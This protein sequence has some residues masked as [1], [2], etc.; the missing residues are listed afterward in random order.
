MYVCV[1]VYI[2]IY[3]LYIY[4]YGL[5]PHGLPPPAPKVPRRG[6][7]AA[8]DT[9][10]PICQSGTASARGGECSPGRAAKKCRGVWQFG[11]QDPNFGPI[12]TSMASIWSPS[13][14]LWAQLQPNIPIEPHFHLRTTWAHDSATWFQVGVAGRPPSWA[15]LGPNPGQFCRFNAAR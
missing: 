9:N 14:S 7:L 8:S 11:Q 3:Y 4:I 15:Q 2:Y 10:G 13:G 6:S 12:W 1:C 5:T